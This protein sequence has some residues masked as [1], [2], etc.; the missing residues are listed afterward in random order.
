MKTARP[1][2]LSVGGTFAFF[3]LA[4]LF[5][6]VGL[7]AFGQSWQAT[8]SFAPAHPAFL[9][10]VHALLLGGLLSVY[11]GAAHQLCPVISERRIQGGGVIAM[12]HAALHLAGTA[13]MVAGFWLARDHLL[14][15]GG[16]LVTAGLLLFALL[17]LS[18]LE[19]RRS[20]EPESVG[21]YAGLWWLLAA[22]ALGLWMASFRAGW[23]SLPVGLE[24]VRGLHLRVAFGGFFLQVLLGLSHRLVPMFLVSRRTG[25]T[26]AGLAL[27]C[28]NL[29]LLLDTVGL[30]GELP[31]LVTAGDTLL[32]LA[33]LPHLVA[34]ACQL[35]SRLRPLGGSFWSY[36]LGTLGLTACAVLWLL[37]VWTPETLTLHAEWLALAAALPLALIPI[38]FAVSARVIPFLVWQV[39]CAPLIGRQ[40]L[41]TVQQL[42]SERL[43]WVEFG[44]VVAVVGTWGFAL[45]APQPAGLVAAMVAT[46]GLFATRALN[47]C[48]LW[49]RL[50][51]FTPVA[52]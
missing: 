26:A 50:R 42:W 48:Q 38:A 44:W 12:V 35:L 34:T 45:F 18:A 16:S 4:T 22:V 9:A 8:G 11:L 37:Q 20:W 17:A 47:C 23:A 52:S 27:L 21:L 25:K 40:K 46:A 28:L 32:G 6:A 3:V 2:L 31:R 1:N 5:T 15:I 43:L 19:R 24:Q 7:V 51:S 29:G 13:L 30:L 41:P 36:S 33:I 49:R 39:A 10:G 14:V